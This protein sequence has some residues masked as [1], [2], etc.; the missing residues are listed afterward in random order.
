MYLI[1]DKENRVLL[2][3][4]CI[5]IMDSLPF[6]KKDIDKDRVGCFVQIMDWIVKKYLQESTIEYLFEQIGNR[7]TPE[8]FGFRLFGEKIFSNKKLFD[9]FTPIVQLLLI[10]LDFVK[11]F[12]NEQDRMWLI[13]TYIHKADFGV[14]R[15]I[16]VLDSQLKNFVLERKKAK[17][18]SSADFHAVILPCFKGIIRDLMGVG[19]N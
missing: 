13:L 6:E 19:K 5:G 3:E 18:F 9:R 8:S 7:R 11:E 12:K 10:A 15:K 2:N 1:I 4:C 17:G 14:E 16:D